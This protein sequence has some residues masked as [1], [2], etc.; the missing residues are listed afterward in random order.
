MDYFYVD[1]KPQADGSHQVH[2]GTCKFLP[3][4]EDRMFL[5]YFD[6]Y[7]DPVVLA[8]NWFPLSTGC[9]H[10]CVTSESSKPGSSKSVQY[11]SYQ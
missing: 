2:R 10:C 8:K 7:E 5:G 11:G 9:K 6:R 1:K 4:N 3:V